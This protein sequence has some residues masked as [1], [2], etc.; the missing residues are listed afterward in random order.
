MTDSGAGMYSLKPVNGEC[1]E[2]ELP[3]CMY[4][5]K[6]YHET[7]QLSNAD[8]PMSAELLELRSRQ[9][10]LIGSLNEI[11]R[12][13]QLVAEQLGCSL[14]NLPADDKPPADNQDEALA[15]LAAAFAPAPGKTIDTGK[16]T[17]AMIAREAHQAN[18]EASIS[19]LDVVVPTLPG[20]TLDYVISVSPERTS[21]T[22]V[23]LASLLKRR[24]LDISVAVHLH[25]SCQQAVPLAYREFACAFY[26]PHRTK[27]LFTYIWKEDTFTPS[28]MLQPAKHS[29]IHGDTNVGRYLARSLA[30]DLYEVGGLHRAT[31]IDRWLDVCAQLTHGSSK[32]RDAA[33]KSLNA[34]LGKQE[35]LVGKSLSLADL[36]TL[37]AVIG[38]QSSF[39][40]LPKNVKRWLGK[41]SGEFPSIV[42]KLNLPESWTK[43]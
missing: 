8:E 16:K 25:S 28:L 43:L 34:E 6:S 22:P 24:G 20:G 15:A 19:L 26:A 21:L 31:A 14:D 10:K 41:M 1:T 12:E 5:M 39:A 37:A 29:R 36:C 4:S 40:S 27:V 2:V 9:E 33:M 7:N 18:P 30:P 23:L 35:Y 17:Y 3:T 42:D 32:E 11:E 13:M 38:S